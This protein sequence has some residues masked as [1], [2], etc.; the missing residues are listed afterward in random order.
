[1]LMKSFEGRKERARRRAA[2]GR[3]IERL[4]ER[5]LLES[6]SRGSWRLTPSGVQAARKLYPGVREL[7]AKELERHNALR[8]LIDS[9]IQEQSA[10]YQAPPDR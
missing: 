9:W 8:V 3:S 5:G 6:C 1:M 10:N 7:S 4:I 2:A